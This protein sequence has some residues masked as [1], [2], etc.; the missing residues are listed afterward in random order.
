MTG[1][2]MYW[3]EGSFTPGIAFTGEPPGMPGSP[4]PTDP[5]DF[6]RLELVSFPTPV[7]GVDTGPT[8]VPVLLTPRTTF[9]VVLGCG[10][11]AG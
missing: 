6:P 7:T 5:K 11:G 2:L 4:L 10:R 9:V 8:A 1:G 3:G